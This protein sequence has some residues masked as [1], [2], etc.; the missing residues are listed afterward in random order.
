M[1]TMRRALFMLLLATAI[2]SVTVL[3]Q[4]EVHY[5]SY[6]V[7]DRDFN[8]L[9]CTTYTLI[10]RN[11]SVLQNGKWYVAKGTVEIEH[12]V[13]VEG[14]ASLILANDCSLTIK[15]GIHVPEGTEISIYGQ[16]EKAGEALGCLVADGRGYNLSGIGGAADETIGN[17][18]VHGGDIH[19]R[20]EDFSS[21]NN[22]IGGIGSTITIYGGKVYTGPEWGTVAVG[23]FSGITGNV[24]TIYGGEVT[25]Y[26]L[27]GCAIGAANGAH[28]VES[29]TIYGGTVKA[30]SGQFS[31]GI[32][33]N[34]YGTYG[35]ITI[36]GGV[37]EAYGGTNG[38]GIGGGQVK[39]TEVKNNGII[40]IC[41]GTVT[42]QGGA[43]AA[44]IGGGYQESGGIIRISGGT[45]DATGGD[46]RAMSAGAGIGGGSFGS[47]GTI[48]ISGGIVTAS[49]AV[50]CGIGGGFRGDGAD[51]TISGGAVTAI[52]RGDGNHGIGGG[53]AYGD[54]CGEMHI[55]GGVLTAMTLEIPDVEA[56]SAI[57]DDYEVIFEE[58]MVPV[59]NVTGQLIE[60][61][62]KTWVETL[63]GTKVSFFAV[64]EPEELYYQ[65][66]NTETETFDSLLCESCTF[67]GGTMT[68]MKNDCYIVDGVVEADTV[69]VTGDV[70]LILRNG[71]QFT[72][73]GGIRVAKGNSLTVFAETPEDGKAVGRLIA[74]G[75]AGAA[76]IGGGED[77]TVGRIVI[78]GGD[79]TAV[80]GTDAVGIG[81]EI[82][83]GG[84]SVKAI[85]GENALA[86]GNGGDGSTFSVFAGTY[87]V[88]N[89][90]YK[91]LKES[92]S[93]KWLACFN[94]QSVSLSTINL[95]HEAQPYLAYHAD[96]DT[97]TEETYTGDY[98]VI[99]S[100]T[101]A[102]NPGWYVSAFKDMT[103]N[104]TLTVSGDVKL[105]LKD[106]T[107]L[108]ARTS[109]LIHDG[110]SLTIYAQSDGKTMG[111]LTAFGDS[112]YPGI[113]GMN[114]TAHN[115]TLVIHGGEVTAYG[116]SGAAGIGGG[117]TDPN[118][119]SLSS[120]YP[121]CDVTICGGKVSA[122]GGSGG[123][124]IG[125]GGAS[126]YDSETLITFAGNG[127][128]LTVY[129]GIVK[130]KGGYNSAGIGGASGT[131][132]GDGGTFTLYGGEVTAT[133][134]HFAAGIGGG[135]KCA[136]FDPAA[137]GGNGATVNV[138]GGTLTAKGGE[139]GIAIGN[140]F[141]GVVTTVSSFIEGGK[142]RIID[143]G[144]V[145]VADGIMLENTVAGKCFFRGFARAD[146]VDVFMEKTVSFKT[147]LPGSYPGEPYL[148]QNSVSS[149]RDYRFVDKDTDVL[150]DGWY[151]VKKGGVSEHPVTVSGKA[152]LIISDD[153]TWEI[154]GGILI[155]D[156]AEL[157]VYVQS[158]GR[159]MGS[160]ICTGDEG[161][162]GIRGSGGSLV[163]F[164][165]NITAQ[166]VRA[167]EGSLAT[168]TGM[169]A[170]DHI[171][172]RVTD[173][174][175]KLKSQE[176]LSVSVV[177]ASDLAFVPYHAYDIETGL[178]T[179]E[180]CESPTLIGTDTR[181]L[182]SGW[183]TTFADLTIDDTLT[184]EGD[185]SIILKDGY[186]L[187][188]TGGIAVNENNRL[189]VYAQSEG[190]NAGKLIATAPERCAGIGGF[191]NNG[192]TIVFHGG[193]IEA[194]GG[195]NGAG[196]GGGYFVGAGKHGSGA[197]ITVY[198]GLI[199]A[200]VNEET[201]GA[202]GIGG[203]FDSTGGRFAMYGGK[204]IVYGGEYSCIGG[205]NYAKFDGSNIFLYGG[206]IEPHKGEGKSKVF[207]G[208]VTLGEGVVL[209][210][211]ESGL[212]IGKGEGQKW[213]DVLYDFSITAVKAGAPLSY[214]VFDAETGAYTT[215]K[216]ETYQLI[217]KDTT[218]LADGCYYAVFGTPTV[219]DDIRVDGNAHLILA[220]NSTLT[221]NGS[222]L[223]DAESSLTVYAQSE[224][225][226]AG[227]LTVNADDGSENPGI[228][229]NGAVIIH[230][231]NVNA[232]GSAVGGAGIGSGYSDVDFDYDIYDDTYEIYSHG[233][234]GD[235]LLYGGNINATGGYNAAG[236]GGGYGSDA[237]HIVIRGGNI[238]AKSGSEYTE[239]IGC[240]WFDNELEYSYTDHVPIDSEKPEIYGGNV[241]S[242][243]NRL[244]VNQQLLSLVLNGKDF[245]VTTDG[246]NVGKGVVAVALYADAGTGRL[247]EV[248]L[249]D[250]AQ[251][252]KPQGTFTADGDYVKAF[253]WR[254][255][256]DLSPLFDAAEKTAAK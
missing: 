127:G 115:K 44:G 253:W 134:D 25:A 246:D 136:G 186:T 110:A 37:V 180:T 162:A 61:T 172:M 194:T 75:S 94:K 160:L 207:C 63:S 125:G 35:S 113:G 201:S 6:D 48:V 220:D 209:V 112:R 116:G 8:D 145:N 52:G 124:G 107:K 95:P 123:A 77:G 9:S 79:V 198:G 244:E 251:T 150:A 229:G 89:D 102:L 163:L 143:N 33:T 2:L 154:N 15:G 119:G 82:I 200:K 189:T 10:D 212:P 126:R 31:A 197:D 252:K 43:G 121:G 203:S 236:I 168:A 99:V 1:K 47:G 13:T 237:G 157:D 74:K 248:K 169:T 146:W 224:G 87:L 120:G 60:K 155:E 100:D 58:G 24:I 56:S 184:V 81:G 16:P 45:V 175:G 118:T 76:G 215:E 223:V 72:A 78:Q 108:T 233:E 202:A 177:P 167:V 243:G 106:N 210:R 139:N 141:V 42:A 219:N 38:A 68:E 111:K 109:I 214:R 4:S 88:D 238:T 26:A 64:K 92:E 242:N 62:K 97:F 191:Y 22:E 40:T 34:M 51:F 46:F 193:D 165:G 216:C 166:G 101:T 181:T 222:V 23:Y 36:R 151:V 50:A 153:C 225:G 245:T 39:D 86:F 70:S 250:L 84:G 98:T 196:I 218:T 54:N 140:G 178:F 130:A 231:G 241:F 247:L 83:L 256:T 173:S 149:C 217:D 152:S 93:A 11:T 57:D 133:G 232:T 142:D 41:G 55:S 59:D 3:A 105:I 85:G 230:G 28:H 234:T 104:K 122:D 199:T 164:G 227:T 144:T 195:Y 135:G 18:T 73:N 185:V 182:N 208:T 29:I 66:Y 65:S 240:G 53:F 21:H 206:T 14:S 32:G 138:Y 171:T 117:S 132:S 239:G 183:Y 204:V 71:C 255:F 131:M 103:L 226:I 249:F 5:L 235:I 254:S 90:T 129:G 128:S 114:A 17:I 190:E 27:E 228:G 19:A 159:A 179:S 7:S 147:V 176:K 188:V 205:Y 148:V 221:V 170:V 20:S 213:E 67:F 69:T 12:T 30:S 91:T 158:Y 156:G 137:L 211:T 187:T 96:T 49:S 192:G 80:G 161:S 174:I